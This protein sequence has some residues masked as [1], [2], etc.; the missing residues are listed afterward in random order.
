MITGTAFSM[1][2]TAR[3]IDRAAVVARLR[4]MPLPSRF[5]QF[6]RWTFSLRNERTITP[7]SLVRE[8][9]FAKAT[10]RVSKAA[11]EGNDRKQ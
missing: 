10:E 7:T 9:D 3:A 1:D 8:R 4:Q 2:G 6:V 11:E 5:M